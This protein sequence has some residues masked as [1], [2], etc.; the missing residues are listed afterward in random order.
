M[1]RFTQRQRRGGGMTAGAPPA[2]PPTITEVQAGSGF[3]VNVRFSSA[4]T[5]DTGVAPDSGFTVNSTPPLTVSVLSADRIN[6]AFG[7]PVGIGDS[8]ILGGQPNWL[9]TLVSWPDSANVT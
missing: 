3:D 6:V 2:P 7:V 8:W 1:G 9:L 5:I 4:V